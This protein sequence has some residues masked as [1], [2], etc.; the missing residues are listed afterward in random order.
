[1]EARTEERHRYEVLLEKI[2]RDVS[3]IAEGQAANARAISELAEGQAAS[4]RAISELAEGQAA[5]ARAISELAEG[6]AA[7]TESIRT[8]QALVEE[9]AGHVRVIAEAHGAN[10]QSIKDT[11]TELERQI[12]QVDDRVIALDVR[13]NQKIDALDTKLSGELARITKHLG[14]DETSHP[15][16]RLPRGTAKRRKAR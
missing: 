11:R 7:N 1:M 14:L 12:K 15:E 2:E 9:L 13:L 10:T 6:Q 16:Q 3:A 4:A 5:S 8:T